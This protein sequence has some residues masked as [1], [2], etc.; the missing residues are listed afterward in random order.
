MNSTIKLQVTTIRNLQQQSGRTNEQG[1]VES[2]IDTYT[3]EK[4]EQTT[5]PQTT[6]VQ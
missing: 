4:F 5:K 6:I 1:N 2:G 3:E